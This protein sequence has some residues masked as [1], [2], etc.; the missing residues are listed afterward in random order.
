MEWPSIRAVNWNET[1][2][3][4]NWIKTMQKNW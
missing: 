2:V 1:V 3:Q 4:Q